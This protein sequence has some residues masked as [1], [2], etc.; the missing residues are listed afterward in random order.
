MVRPPKLDFLLYSFDR[1][2]GTTSEGLLSVYSFES[3][4]YFVTYAPPQVP[5]T[6]LPAHHLNRFIGKV[7]GECPYLT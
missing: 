7:C 4:T 3:D 2:L 1:T 5:P 6:A